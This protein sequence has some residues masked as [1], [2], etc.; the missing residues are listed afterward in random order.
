MKTRISAA[1]LVFAIIASLPLMAV[2]SFEI[3][4]RNVTEESV[5][6]LPPAP[7][8]EIPIWSNALTMV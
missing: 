2:E 5:S 8:A 1:I 3:T 7:T 6:Y 4:K